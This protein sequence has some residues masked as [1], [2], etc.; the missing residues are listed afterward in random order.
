MCKAE[1]PN[2]VYQAP[3]TS[4]QFLF[5]PHN[6]DPTS[7][8]NQDGTSTT[9]DPTDSSTDNGINTE[10][11]IQVQPIR[12]IVISV[13][14]MLPGSPR[15]IDI[16]PPTSP[17]PLDS[18]SRSLKARARQKRNN[19]NQAYVYKPVAREGE[20][21]V[22]ECAARGNPPPKLIWFKGGGGSSL[23]RP[24]GLSS[25]DEVTF[26]ALIK[27]ALTYLPLTEAM[28]YLGTKI[29]ED[30]QLFPA[31]VESSSD[32]NISDVK[33]LTE[34]DVAT[35][36]PKEPDFKGTKLGRFAVVSGLK[37]DDK[38]LPLIA[39]SRLS[40]DKL[41]VSDATRYTCL[42]QLNMEQLGGRGNKTAIGSLLPAIILMPQFIAAGTKLYATG[43]PGD[44][45]TLT[46]E[47]LGGL[48][49]NGGFNLTLLRGSG[50]K[51]LAEQTS[52]AKKT[53]SPAG[54]LS[55]NV[56]ETSDYLDERPEFAFSKSIEVI[57]N[58]TNDRY[59]LTSGPDPRNPYAA[60]VRLTITVPSVLTSDKLPPRLVASTMDEDK[61]GEKGRS[62]EE[63]FF[64]IS[65][66]RPEDNNYYV[67][68][69]RSGENWIA[70]APSPEDALGRLSVW[71]APP[72][73]GPPPEESAHSSSS[74]RKPNGDREGKWEVRYGLAHK[75]SRLE[76]RALGQPSP[77]WTWTGPAIRNPIEPVTTDEVMEA[78]EYT[79]RVYQL[80]EESVSELILPAA[81]WSFGIFGS[82]SCTA[83]NR[84]GSATGYVRLK[85]ATHPLRPNVTACTVEPTVVVLCVSPPEETGG[86][87]LTHYELR[88]QPGPTDRFHGPF[89]Y[90]AD[91]DVTSSDYLARW[92]L[93]SDGGSPVIMYK[94]KIRPV[95][96]NWASV[97]NKVTPLG[98]WTVFDVSSQDAV[99]LT[100]NGMEG[101]YRIKSLQ[102]GTSYEVDLVG[103][104]SVGQSNPY[105]V[106]F[107][108]SDLLGTSGKLLQEPKSQF[109]HGNGGNKIPSNWM[110]L[111][112]LPLIRL[113][114]WLSL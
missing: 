50:L 110:L 41:G 79:V 58:K 56:G 103:Q 63:F 45:A 54:F 10:F 85:L 43:Y 97:Q 114:S 29:A 28:K 42:G 98:T 95:N 39:V 57:S 109:L 96:T 49:M 6:S 38:G 7:S 112:V 62:T 71:F 69:A 78:E 25:K 60:M 53:I 87:P 64:L 104:N 88:I 91:T 84:L 82:Y 108:T 32:Y 2:P 17:P 19:D 75:P 15:L 20:K 48:H 37:K 102:P 12:L 93:E 113:H 55:N 59:R 61:E 105:A 5:P 23:P 111:T 66:L 13:P 3:S 74:Q 4:D 81:Y 72:K 22:L 36:M 99:R 89:A 73:A 90:L 26:D 51:E 65:D 67:C 100:P 70:Y 47:A 46:C 1:A 68:M 44:N 40:V 80:G 52:T 35:L 16:S 11:L 94:I 83:E 14:Q 101:M 107:R 30:I 21:M 77:H 86:L 106:V 18:W 34:S 92:I 33:P 24:K 31:I 9:L 8:A 76:C 27:E